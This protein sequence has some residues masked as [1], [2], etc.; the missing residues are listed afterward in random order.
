MKCET[1]EF[2]PGGDVEYYRSLGVYRN[3]TIVG[4][5]G[6]SLQNRPGERCT[7]FIDTH[8]DR[9]AGSPDLVVLVRSPD[10]EEMWRNAVSATLDQDLWPQLSSTP[11][12]VRIWM[13]MVRMMPFVGG[14]LW[15]HIIRCVLWVQ[16]LLIYQRHEYWVWCGVIHVCQYFH[17]PGEMAPEW[18]QN[19]EWKSAEILTRLSMRVARVG[20]PLLGLKDGYPEYCNPTGI[21]DDES[22]L[23][24]THG[25]GKGYVV[26][27]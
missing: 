1:M 2:L 12:L 20:S 14:R 21:A 7:W 13:R 5:W 25:L 22:Q 10:N 8:H 26:A 15:R 11:Q 4:K 23:S 6:M 17:E 27:G 19:L 24:G 16:L 18:A 9:P 3:S